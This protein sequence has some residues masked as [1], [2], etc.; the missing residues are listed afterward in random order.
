VPNQVYDA[1]GGRLMAGALGNDD[2]P[3]GGDKAGYRCHRGVRIVWSSQ[4]QLTNGSEIAL[5]HR[6]ISVP[7]GPRF[8]KLP[9]FAQNLVPAS[10]LGPLP[11]SAGLG[12][13]VMHHDGVGL[14][15]LA[16]SINTIR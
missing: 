2:S 9:S 15:A 10:S 13:T 16:V 3:E 14:Q 11:A 4:G 12:R 1:R 6:K 8:A 5:N 7:P